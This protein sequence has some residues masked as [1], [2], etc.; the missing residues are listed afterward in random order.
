MQ[1]R[2]NGSHGGRFSVRSNT[3]LI[4]ASSFGI[5]QLTFRKDKRA[6]LDLLSEFNRPEC[7]L[8]FVSGR[9]DALLYRK[10]DRNRT[11][12]DCC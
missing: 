1:R 6:R 12:N 9:E 3:P 10:L 2:G 7:E 5:A 8:A 4:L 11:E